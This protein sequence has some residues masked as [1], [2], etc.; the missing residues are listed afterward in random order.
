MLELLEKYAFLNNRIVES[1][2]KFFP[3]SPHDQNRDGD[4]NQREPEGGCREDEDVSESENQHDA[5]W[6]CFGKFDGSCC[7]APG[8]ISQSGYHL[9]L[10]N[11]FKGVAGGFSNFI[12][13]LDTEIAD[14]ILGKHRH[15]F[16]QILF[17]KDK[18]SNRK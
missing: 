5:G 15:L 8:L 18:G 2:S 16:A 11:F 17:E 10:A 6:G 9:C 4:G 7:D 3:V 1:V 12:C 13:D 14:G